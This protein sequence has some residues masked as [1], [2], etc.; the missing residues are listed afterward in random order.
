MSVFLYGCQNWTLTAETE[1]RIQAF[2][3]KLKLLKIARWSVE[4]FPDCFF[5]F[6]LFLNVLNVQELQQQQ[7]Q[8]LNDQNLFTYY[9]FK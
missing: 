1:H 6:V 2:E 5:V 7:Q 3:Q 4:K 8:K 9:I